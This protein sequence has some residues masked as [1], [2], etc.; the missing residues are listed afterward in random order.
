MRS[1]VAVRELGAARAFSGAF[2]G[3]ERILADGWRIA[4]V[5]DW[6][7]FIAETLAEVAAETARPVLFA[8]EA[9][10]GSEGDA[11][12]Q[13][14]VHLPSEPLT[15][16]AW[17]GADAAA[18]AGNDLE[19]Y[20]EAAA[21]QLLVVWSQ[22]AGLRPD[23]ATLAIALGRAELSVDELLR[24]LLVGVGVLPGGTRVTCS[25]GSRIGSRSGRR[26]RSSR[27]TY[28]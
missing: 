15:F 23:T 8:V 16:N 12:V 9:D 26:S 10:D 22:E 4:R 11:F 21:H 28:C 5:G 14:A 20:D 24:T 18:A 3:D 2:V 17:L 1:S 19:G 13:V 7:D 25:S 27:W 6:P